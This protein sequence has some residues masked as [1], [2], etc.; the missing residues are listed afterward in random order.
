MR[1]PCSNQ[2]GTYSELGMKAVAR[3]LNDV[4]VKM[5]RAEKVSDKMWQEAEGG[6]R[7]QLDF[8]IKQFSRDCE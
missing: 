1:N 6:K 5:T 7:E 4:D 2:T 8:L 3:S